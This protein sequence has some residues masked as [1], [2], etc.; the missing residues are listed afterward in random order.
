MKSDERQKLIE[1]LAAETQKLAE[2][3]DFVDLEKKG[4][5]VKAGAWYR[6]P[7]FRKLPENVTTKVREIAQDSKGVKVKL[8]KAT[9]FDKLV[10]KFEKLSK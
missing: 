3:V 4:V 1:E 7:D 10:R 8:Y 2:P 6:V 5:L 9:K